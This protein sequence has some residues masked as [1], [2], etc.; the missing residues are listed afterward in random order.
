M[1]ILLSLLALSTLHAAE[2]FTGTLLPQKCRNDNPATHTRD[3]ALK[4]AETG[5]GI[6]LN[7]GEYAAFAQSSQDKALEFLKSTAKKTDL[8]IRVTGKRESK[9]IV[10]ET[11]ELV[12]EPRK[13]TILIF[14]GVQI[15]DFTGPYEILTDTFTR[16]EPVFN[17]YTVAEE[18]RPIRT[19]GGMSLNPTYSFKDAPVPDILIIPGGSIPESNDVVA[20]W[21]KKTTPA[22][23]IT[24]TVCNGVFL[25]ARAGLT[26]DLRLT[27]TGGNLA[28]LK[29]IAPDAHI[30]ADA[31]VTDNGRIITSG[32]LSAGM[33]G[34]R[35]LVERVA[36]RAT[37]Q[38][39][40]TFIEY[41]WQPTSDF[42][43]GTLAYKHLAPA[44]FAVALPMRG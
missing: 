33:D 5:L 16:G 22:T 28:R 17:V 2:T 25:L 11:I 38:M 24:L 8:R 27:T 6:V 13:T 15:I 30:D 1:R 31:R 41:N 19:T 9:S 7:G 21:L 42:K 44:I 37:A 36:G 23:E 4:C 32:G 14:D 20:A 26:K 3:C 18:K 12:D 39:V 10:I 29:S 35:H 34:A 40:A 43:P